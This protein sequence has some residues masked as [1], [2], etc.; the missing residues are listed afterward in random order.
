MLSGQGRASHGPVAP[1]VMR[2]GKRGGDAY[3]FFVPWIA[4]WP[5]FWAVFGSTDRGSLG[6]CSPRCSVGKFSW[7]LGILSLDYS[8]DSGM[9]L[10]VSA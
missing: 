4:V 5:S 9:K 2:P 8:R 10:P 1:T 3:F 6:F 7:L